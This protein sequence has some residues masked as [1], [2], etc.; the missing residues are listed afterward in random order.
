ML[1]QNKMLLSIKKLVECPTVGGRE[2]DSFEFIK[3][4]PGENE[5]VLQ[6]VQISIRPIKES[7]KQLLTQICKF[8]INALMFSFRLRL[9]ER[10]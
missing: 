1:Y 3:L 9:D 2:N 4:A 8:W 10:I 6:K 7:C 5:A